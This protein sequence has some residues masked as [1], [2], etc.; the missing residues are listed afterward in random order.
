MRVVT[1]FLPMIISRRAFS[2]NDNR[3]V[4]QELRDFIRSKRAALAGFMQAGAELELKE[5]VLIVTPRVDIYT[6][7]SSKPNP[8]GFIG[9]FDRVSRRDSRWYAGRFAQWTP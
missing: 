7:G 9:G 3:H 2:R 4:G 8:S 5:D 1:R 6:C